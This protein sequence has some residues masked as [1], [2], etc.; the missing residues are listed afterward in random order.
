MAAARLAT[1]KRSRPAGARRAILSSVTLLAAFVS[2]HG[3]GHATRTSAVLAALRARWPALALHVFTEAPRQVFEASI[4][5]G[6]EWHRAWTDVGLVQKTPFAEDLPG[7]V[8]R[9]SEH[10]PF[11]P[12]EVDRLARQLRGLGAQAVLCDISP[13]GLMAARA[14]G[15]PSILIENFTWDWIYRGYL[16]SEPRLGPLADAL[17][18]ALDSVTLHLQTGP[19]GVERAKAVRLGLIS[20]PPRRSR[21]EVRAALGLAGRDRAVL[22]TLGGIRWDLAAPPPLPEGVTLLVPAPGAAC[23]GP[24]ERVR[25]LGPGWFHPDLIAAADAVVMKAGYS[26]LAEVH[27]AG[28]PV[29][30]IPRPRFRESAVLEAFALGALPCR[31]L[32]PDAA[33]T[34]SWAGALPELLA[35]EPTPPLQGTAGA[36]EAAALIGDLL[37]S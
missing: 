30:L 3:F 22:F 34:G 10:V 8:A 33:E 6:I 9:L 4:P 15:L 23:D 20:R 26:T 16:G 18:A 36:E 28:V 7:T 25:L 17:E 5:G 37:E 2:S 27:R 13:L 35:L 12:E 21:E 29:G 1:N 32:A 19:V 24:R 11:R 31:V 14:A